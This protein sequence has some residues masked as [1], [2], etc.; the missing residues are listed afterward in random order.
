[1]S[2]HKNKLVGF[3]PPSELMEEVKARAK[4]QGQTVTELIVDALWF[5]LLNKPESQQ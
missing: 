1:M 2:R 3:H 5:Y 4:R